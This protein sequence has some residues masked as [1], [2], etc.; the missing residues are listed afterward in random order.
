MS[1]ATRRTTVA[2]TRSRSASIDG[3][4]SDPPGVVSGDGVPGNASGRRLSTLPCHP[5][6][7]PP[8][9][10]RPLPLSSCARSP[11]H[12]ESAGEGSRP[13][14]GLYRPSRPAVRLSTATPR[15]RPERSRRISF[16]P[17]IITCA[18]FDT[19]PHVSS[20]AQSRDLGVT[21]RGVPMVSITMGVGSDHWW[22]V[23]PRSVDCARDDTCT[24]AEE[25]GQA[26]LE[27]A[28]AARRGRDP[29]P[30]GSG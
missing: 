18:P 23:R 4:A 25:R 15:C 1:R 29:S 11:C 19:H 28:A 6:P 12:P 17:S 26:G 5:E 9:I 24:W 2:V 8:V 14:L 16:S 10:L 7:A 21:N 13:S 20:R 22:W 3:A 30:A 27:V